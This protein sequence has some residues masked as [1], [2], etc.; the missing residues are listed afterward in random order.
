MWPRIIQVN[1]SYKHS[2][3]Q[4]IKMTQ[5]FPLNFVIIEA[6]TVI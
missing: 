3:L 4:I 6:A 2:E 5:V 1:P